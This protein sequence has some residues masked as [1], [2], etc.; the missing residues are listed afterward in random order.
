MLTHFYN[1]L[2]LKRFVVYV[3]KQ[4]SK[5]YHIDNSSNQMLIKMDFINIA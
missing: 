4:L 1:D 5:L 3:I 2:V